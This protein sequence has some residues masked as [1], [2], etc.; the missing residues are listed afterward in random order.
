M[1]ASVRCRWWPLLPA[2]VLGAWVGVPTQARASCG[3]Y[4]V[5]GGK[6]GHAGNMAPTA[7]APNDGRPSPAQ[8]P[9]Q[10]QPC[11][12]PSC[13][14]SSTPFV[15][16]APAPAPTGPQGDEWGWVS[17]APLGRDA[18]WGRGLCDFG[19]SCPFSLPTSIFHP[20]RCAVAMS[21]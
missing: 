4:V 21:A 12:G 20:P 16:V 1:R 6:P 8:L 9:N 11:H 3:D 19:L 5:I 15:P 2:L 13:S 10:G 7:P 17:T 18:G 14:G